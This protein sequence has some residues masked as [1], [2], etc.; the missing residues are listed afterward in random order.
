VPHGTQ[1]AGL[2]SL[3]EQLRDVPLRPAGGLAHGL[4]GDTA[5][6]GNAGGHGG[7]SGQ[8]FFFDGGGYGSCLSMKTRID[9]HADGRAAFLD[10]ADV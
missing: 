5:E 6:R 1:T 7:P 10:A 3:R 9:G 4:R 8:H 2:A